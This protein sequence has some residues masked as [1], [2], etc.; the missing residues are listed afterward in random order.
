MQ[1]LPPQPSQNLNRA[2][3]GS[4]DGSNINI[5]SGQEQQNNIA[6]S[7]QRGK[8]LQKAIQTVISSREDLVQYLRSAGLDLVT[9]GVEFQ[10]TGDFIQSS[11]VVYP[12]HNNQKEALRSFINR[13]PQLKDSIEAIN[14]TL[15]PVQTYMQI[16]TK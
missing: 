12:S 3:I 15:R 14:Q 13:Y 9:S 2:N 6:S 16:R 1:P 8:A 11:Y 4:P 5:A 7:V 10:D